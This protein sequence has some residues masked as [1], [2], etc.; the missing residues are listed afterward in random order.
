MNKQDDVEDLLW[1]QNG[2]KRLMTASSWFVPCQLE[3]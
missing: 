3:L 2:W 1:R